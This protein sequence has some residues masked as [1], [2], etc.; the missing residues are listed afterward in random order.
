MTSKKLLTLQEMHQFS[1]NI[2]YELQ[3]EKIKKEL[4]LSEVQKQIDEL[5][6]FLS[7]HLFVLR[8]KRII[9]RIFNN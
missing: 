4:M 2:F 1:E 3:D 9:R 8:F 6:K 5:P 7:I